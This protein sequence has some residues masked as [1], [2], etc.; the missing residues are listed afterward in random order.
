MWTISIWSGEANDLLINAQIDT[1]VTGEALGGREAVELTKR[2]HPHE[3][4]MD[5]QMSEGGD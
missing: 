3:V 2:I 1:E 4:L 5:V